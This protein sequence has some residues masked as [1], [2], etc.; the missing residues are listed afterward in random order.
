MTF[1]EQIVVQLDL[2][3]TNVTV[4]YNAIDNLDLKLFTF[5]L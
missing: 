1:S 2:T 4:V 3:K 5:F